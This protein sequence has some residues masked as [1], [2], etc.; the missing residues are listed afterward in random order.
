M[1]QNPVQRINGW[2]FVAKRLD[3]RGF[4]QELGQIMLVK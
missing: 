4:A 1:I 3:E 2:G